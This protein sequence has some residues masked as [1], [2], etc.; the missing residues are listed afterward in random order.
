M[1][2]LFRKI[3]SDRHPL[4]LF[5]HKI[6][7]FLAAIMYWF[8]ADNLIVVGITGTNGKTTTTNLLANIL[9]H[10][11]YKVGMTSSINFQ[12]GEKKWANITKQTTLGPFFMQ[13]MLRRMVKEGCKYAVLEV[14]SHAL[15][16]SRVY[17][18]NFDVA[19]ITNV[20][21]DHVEYHGG[22]GSYLAT[23]TELFKKVSKGKKKFGVQK[24]LVLNAD[25]ENFSLFDQFV[26][27]RK[28]TY[29]LKAAN[30]FAADIQKFPEGSQFVLH[31]PNNA[32][33][34]KFKMPGD[35]NIYNALAAVSAAISLQV[36]MEMIKAG[37][38]ASES[39]A[40]RFEHVN[41]GQKYSIIID[42][43]HGP[44]SLES[45]LSLYRKLTKGKLFVAFGAT[46]GGRDKKKRPKMGAI[47]NEYA[48]FIVVTDDD[49]YA[50]DEW[51][52]IEQVAEGIPRREGYNF[53]RIPDRYEAIRLILNLAREGD[54]VVVPG[55]G[56]EEV[57][58]VRGKTI[59][60]SDKQ[61]ITEILQKDVE[62]E[63]APDQFE[64][65]ENVYK[66]S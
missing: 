15:L 45:L 59:P 54:T 1:I 38:E 32:M 21:P 16:Q 58:M 36:P 12:I 18:I 40:G 25:D 9:A 56:A 52:I 33:P 4:R 8:P 3:I 47:A 19:V 14:T 37:L 49:P 64:E 60:W 34:V 41:V 17:G 51:E 13:K 28:I 6:L 63:I 20:T 42:Y 23:K 53:W 35:F 65:R 62:V 48:D 27:D 26:A 66:M 22:F 10:A 50:D 57:M 11:G 61:V 55:K 5:Y 31:V 7:G 43:A 46:G 44:E 29:G 2:D 39:V 24:V 30:V